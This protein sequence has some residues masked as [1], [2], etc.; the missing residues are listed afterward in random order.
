MRRRGAEVHKLSQKFKVFV[1]A[2]LLPIAIGMERGWVEE[3]K[4]SSPN[5]FSYEE[6]GDKTLVNIFQYC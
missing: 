4:T 3:T 2:P 1:F 6:K 5:P